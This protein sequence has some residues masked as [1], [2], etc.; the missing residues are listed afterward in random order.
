MICVGISV[1]MELKHL[2]I[3]MRGLDP[4]IERREGD[5]K[6]DHWIKI[7][8]EKGELEPLKVSDQC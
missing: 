7:L 5:F 2:G 8:A 1:A 6:E 4:P 3:G